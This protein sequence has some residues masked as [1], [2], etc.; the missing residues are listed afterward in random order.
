MPHLVT[1]V[2]VHFKTGGDPVNFTCDEKRGDVME[3][4]PGERIYR[5][6]LGDGLEEVHIVRWEEV[7]YARFTQRLEEEPA[8]VYAGDG[9]TVVG[10]LPDML[11]RRV[12]PS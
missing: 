6:Q 4:A 11:G 12:R 7:R 10:E 2:E 9:V 1:D 8:P 5:V 3:A